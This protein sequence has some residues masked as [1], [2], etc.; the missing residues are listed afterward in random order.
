MNPRFYLPAIYFLIVLSSCTMILSTNVPGKQEKSL[1]KEWIGRY[2]II[3]SPY[4]P[5]KRDTAQH[6]KEY[7]IFESDR[8]IWE[9]ADGT[10]VYSLA[11]SLKYSVI[12]GQS[13]YLSLLM[14]QGLYAVFKVIKKD[15]GLELYSMSSDDE[16]RKGELNK[17]FAKVEKMKKHEDE[18]YRVTIVDKKLDAYFKS[19]I[20]SKDVTKLVL[21]KQ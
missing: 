6:E 8:I 21:V 10:K 11:D 1:P 17:Y 5:E 7:A 16:P 2:K 4:F 14:P 13:R 3:S 19:S 15:D 12:Y 18:Y 20:P 9:G